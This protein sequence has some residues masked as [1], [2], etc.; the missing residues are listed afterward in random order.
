MG[1][2]GFERLR[3]VLDVAANRAGRHVQPLFPSSIGSRRGS[4]AHASRNIDHQRRWRLRRAAGR[5]MLGTEDDHVSVTR[6]GGRGDEQRAVT[7]VVQ[8]VAD[9]L[10]GRPLLLRGPRWRQADPGQAR[11]RRGVPPVQIDAPPPQ[12]SRDGTGRRKSGT[13]QSAIP[14]G[15]P[16]VGLV[17]E[18]PRRH[19]GASLPAAVG[20]LGR[21]VEQ[22][23]AAGGCD[24]RTRRGRCRWCRARAVGSVWAGAVGCQLGCQWQKESC[25]HGALLR[26]TCREYR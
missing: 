7:L 17:S 4:G 9:L 6:S 5:P 10:A 26:Q 3:R 13:G 19:G 24:G 8:R 25:P 21:L 20:R 12:I 23:G 15:P 1:A 11:R 16:R 14:L 22:V 18:I 2:C